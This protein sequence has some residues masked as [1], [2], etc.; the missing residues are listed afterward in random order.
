MKNGSN[1]AR[2]IPGANLIIYLNTGHALITERAEEF[3]RD[4]LN[5]LN[6]SSPD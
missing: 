5:F 3:N 4:V 2:R 1:L 6:H